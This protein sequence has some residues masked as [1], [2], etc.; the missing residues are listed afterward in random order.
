MDTPPDG[1]ERRHYPPRSGAGAINLQSC[2]PNA[3]SHTAGTDDE[4]AAETLRNRRFN[5]EISRE[6]C[7]K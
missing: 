1:P 5:R 7:D 2:S 3:D 4:S 6:I